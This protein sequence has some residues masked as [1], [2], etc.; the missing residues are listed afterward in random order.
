MTRKSWTIVISLSFIILVIS[1][2]IFVRGGAVSLQTKNEQQFP[3]PIG[4]IN[5]FG[6]LLSEEENR[7]LTTEAADFEKRTTAQL[8]VLT[9]ETTHPYETIELYATK[10]FNQWGIGQKDKN[11]G[12]LLLVAIKER[13]VRIEVGRGLESTLPDAK[14]K[15]I[16]QT[17]V[18]PRLRAKEYF[19]A[20]QN[21]MEA[22][23]K[24]IERH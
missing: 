1:G 9:I 8:A 24:E 12:L 19:P 3:K 20:L 14:C 16:L 13:Q 18:T 4:Y 21:G 11:N 23:M 5:D 17:Q 6:H 2:L 7:I 10:I 22:M 15:E